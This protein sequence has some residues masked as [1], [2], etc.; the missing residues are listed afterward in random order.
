M[1]IK[2]VIEKCF[3]E[4]KK[5]PSDINEHLQTLYEYALLCNTVTEFGTRHGTSTWAFLHAAPKN[6]LCY[7]IHRPLSP[8]LDKLL[9]IAKERNL[10]YKNIDVLETQ[11]PITDLLFIDTLHT[12][13]QLYKELTLHSKNVSK[14]IILHD[15]VTYGY[16]DEIVYEHA[17]KYITKQENK[18]GLVPALNDF[19]ITED[20][21][22]W[23][24]HQTF[25]NNNGLT[26]LR[27]A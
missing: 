2:S 5:H 3:F 17:S 7:D 24:I 6:I 4:K 26:I 15:T 16:V 14:Y 13:E 25:N 23:V 20:G 27:R 12:Y 21:K 18:H 11:I 22:N 9:E 10:T 8:D 19:L 1:D